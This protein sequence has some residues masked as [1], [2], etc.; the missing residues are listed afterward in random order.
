MLG[1]IAD[2]DAKPGQIPFHPHQEEIGI[3]TAV[4]VGVKN[5]AVVTVNKFC[6]AGHNA[7][8]VG[9]SDQQHSGG[10]WASGI[11]DGRGMASAAD[12]GRTADGAAYLQ[13]MS[14]P[15]VLLAGRLAV[16]AKRAGIQFLAQERVLKTSHGPVQDGDDHL[17]VNIGSYFAALPF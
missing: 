10:V 3:G 14:D 6:N 2:F 8:A 1:E 7:F 5:V 13:K 4:L 17:Q 12:H 9:T 16:A 11:R 15:G